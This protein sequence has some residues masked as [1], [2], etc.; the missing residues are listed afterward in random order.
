M[1]IFQSL[2][3]TRYLL[4]DPNGMPSIFF[5]VYTGLL[6]LLLIASVYAYL[7]R[8]RLAR[9]VVPRRQLIRSAAK[10]GM[11]VASIGLFLALMRYLQVPYLDA[12]VLT[13]LLLLSAIAYVGYLTYYLSE[14][15][16]LLLSRYQQAA[17]ER[18]YRV[19]AK[20][21]PVTAASVPRPALQRGKRRR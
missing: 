17:F 6:G 1:N 16:P 9:G 2:W 14:R 4:D 19:T 10:A 13:Y 8:N 18:R 11:W 7:R 3:S 15:Y 21:K 5:D 12:R 20:R